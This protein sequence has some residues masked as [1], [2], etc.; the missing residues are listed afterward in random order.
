MG[1]GDG[2]QE[3]RDSV[4]KGTYLC[5]HCKLRFPNPQR[6]LGAA[7]LDG[8]QASSQ[9]LIERK[10]KNA[11]FWLNL[12]ESGIYHTLPQLSFMFPLLF[13]FLSVL[14]RIESQLGDE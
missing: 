4:V 6:I 7:F 10:E 5:L 13:P 14:Y 11:R 2:V 3:I 1:T 9:S 12:T 8:Q